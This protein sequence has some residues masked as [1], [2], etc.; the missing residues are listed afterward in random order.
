[1]RIGFVIWEIY[2]LLFFSIFYS[3]TICNKKTLS[4]ERKQICVR[5]LI[6]I[7]L[8]TKKKEDILKSS[9]W[10]EAF[11]IIEE[12]GQPGNQML[13]IVLQ[14][15][16]ILIYSYHPMKVLHHAVAMLRLSYK[17]YKTMCFL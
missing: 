15:K 11:A 5:P 7:E 16:M 3:S 17:T 6:F 8:S 12:T 9:M 14:M 1:M 10:K 13:S 4:S 2:E